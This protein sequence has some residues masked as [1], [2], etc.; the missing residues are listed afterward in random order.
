MV[1][2][3]NWYSK[4]KILASLNIVK[5]SVKCSICL[6]IRFSLLN[7]VILFLAANFC[8]L[9]NF[10]PLIITYTSEVQLKPKYSRNLVFENYLCCDFFTLAFS[11]HSIETIWSNFCFQTSFPFTQIIYAI[12]AYRMEHY[13]KI[14]GKFSGSKL[15]SGFFFLTLLTVQ[16]ITPNCKQIENGLTP[17]KNQFLL[18][19]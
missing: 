19:D 17:S 3:W 12:L 11:W 1:I 13:I 10:N 9:R 18:K 2:N 6:T 14:H 5:L 16:K 7:H 4:R 15:Q 8:S